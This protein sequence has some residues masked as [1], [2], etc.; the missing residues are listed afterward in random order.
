MLYNAVGLLSSVFFIGCLF[1]LVDQI[2]RI[3]RRKASAENQ[4]AGF[5]TQ[6]L[7]ANAFFSSFIAFYAF[8]LYSMMLDEIEPYMFVTRLFAA[9]ITLLVLYELYIDRQAL[10]QRLPFMVGVGCMLLA[11]VA[12][13]YRQEL[14]VVGRSTSIV[15]ALGAT[16]LMLQGGIQQIRKLAKTKQTGALSLPMNVV[17]MAKDLAN[18][19]FGLVLGFE[20][21]WPL[22][23]LGTISAVIKLVII[24]QFFRY[25]PTVIGNSI[26]S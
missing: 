22:L 24:V 21:G 14:L 10:S 8:F 9:L 20:D 5:A 2:R 3:R 25:R 4:W 13:I 17:F 12:Y 18:V 19:A 11:V 1:G 26:S 15:L 6:S 23:M 7:S 16:A